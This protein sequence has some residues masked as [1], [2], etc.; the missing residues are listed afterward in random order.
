MKNAVA[1]T[2]EVYEQSI[3]SRCWRFTAFDEGWDKCAAIRESAELRQIIALEQSIAPV[4]LWAVEIVERV[5]NYPPFCP[6]HTFPRP[7]LDVLDAIGR[8]QPPDFIHGCYTA[9]RERKNRMRDYLFCLDAWLAGISPEKAF[10]ELRQRG[11]QNVNWQ[12]VC[13]HIRQI[14]GA[15]TE[16]KELL[17]T[18][19]IHRQRWWI[20]SLV[21]DD[22]DRNAYYQDQYL[23]DIHCPGDHYGN[24]AFRDPYFTELEVPRIKN[25]ETVLSEIC[26]DW[27]WFR[28]IIHNSWLCAPKAFRFL[29]RLLWAIGRGQTCVSLPGHPLKN[30]DRVPDFLQCEAT[31]PDPIVSRKWIG[32]FLEGLHAW[33]QNSRPTEDVGAEVYR[34]LGERTEIKYWLVRLYLLKMTHLNPFG[35]IGNSAEL[36]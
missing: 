26:S 24:P 4:P 20:K 1:V 35:A 9:T 13:Q 3:S 16:L 30:G 23:G 32:N 6:H 17:I 11:D 34:R 28:E 8:Q 19:V 18:R 31:Y 5:I 2:R 15:R 21:W 22:A 14:L 7:Y 29:E 27:D 12:S 33:I 25:M 10:F 36:T